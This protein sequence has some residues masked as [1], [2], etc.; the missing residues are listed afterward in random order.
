MRYRTDVPVP[1][2][3]PFYLF[4][5]RLYAGPDLELLERASQLALEPGERLV[6][7][8][9]LIQRA[10]TEFVANGERERDAV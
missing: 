3:N 5:A 4:S 6:T 7:N 1:K 8:R 9:A 2:T 10:L